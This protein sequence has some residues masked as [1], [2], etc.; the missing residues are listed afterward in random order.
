MLYSVFHSMRQHQLIHVRQ[1]GPIF[2]HQL[3]EIHRK[4]VMMFQ[5]LL[6]LSVPDRLVVFQNP[7]QH[8]L[9]RHLDDSGGHDRFRFLLRIHSGKIKEK[10]NYFNCFW[11]KEVA[12]IVNKIN[13]KRKSAR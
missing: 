7:K 3:D 2:D 6:E 8:R 12:F 9:K 13:K 4:D 1:F 11:L 10:K 5:L